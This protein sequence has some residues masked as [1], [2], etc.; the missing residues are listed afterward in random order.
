MDVFTGLRF[1]I[2][3]MLISVFYRVTCAALIGLS[4]VIVTP[5]MHGT[6]HSI[7]R[8]ETDNNYCIVLTFWNQLHRTF[9]IDIPQEAINI[10]VPYV[11]KHLEAGE[12]M[13]MPWEKAGKWELSEGTV[14]QKVPVSLPTDDIKDL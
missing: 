10:G 14:P 9:R 6:Y 2:G 11:R 4:R 12:L 3:E 7:V 1:H 13:K 5:R 8:Q